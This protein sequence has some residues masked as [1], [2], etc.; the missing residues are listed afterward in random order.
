MRL[1]LGAG[2]ARSCG[3]AHAEPRGTEG[4]HGGRDQLLHPAH[5]AQRRRARHRDDRTGRAHRPRCADRRAAAVRRQPA[6]WRAVREPGQAR[7]RHPEDGGRRA[8]HHRRHGRHRPRV[9][10]RR[11]RLGILCRPRDRD[12][13]RHQLR[14]CRARAGVCAGAAAMAAIP[15][16]GRSRAGPAGGAHARRPWARPAVRMAR[17]RDQRPP[18]RARRR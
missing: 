4:R 5:S 11:T 10:R 18:H 14:P 7:Q 1:L 16:A 12:R 17:P 2:V 3:R 13:P 8:R 9:R 15:R 6:G